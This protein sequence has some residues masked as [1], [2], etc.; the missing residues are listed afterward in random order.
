MTEPII[1]HC[2]CQRETWHRILAVILP[3]GRLEMKNDGKSSVVSG[4]RVE[5]S[6]SRC[7]FDR[8]ITLDKEAPRVLA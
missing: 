1:I 7:G 5:L 2:L 6:C 8:Q 3:D 4:G